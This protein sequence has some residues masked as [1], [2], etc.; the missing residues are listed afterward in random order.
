MCCKLTWFRRPS[1]AVDRRCHRLLIEVP[2]TTSKGQIGNM[3][4]Q[5]SCSCLSNVVGRHLEC[6]YNY[7]KL[8]PDRSRNNLLAPKP[9]AEVARSNYLLPFLFHSKSRTEVGLLDQELPQ[10]GP[11]ENAR[12][13]TL[14]LHKL[15][16]VADLLCH[17]GYGYRLFLLE[18]IASHRQTA[19]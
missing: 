15:A 1:R 18:A 17:Q 2:H 12:Y 16:P 8:Q 14:P 9:T 3:D 6:S 4:S 11:R 19:A 7:R 5:Y 13:Y 10:V